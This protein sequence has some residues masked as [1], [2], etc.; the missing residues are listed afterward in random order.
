MGRQGA[1]AHRD[2]ALPL[3]EAPRDGRAQG[4]APPPPDADLG[5]L[6]PASAPIVCPDCK[7]R[8]WL[9]PLQEGGFADL[10]GCRGGA[11]RASAT[12]ATAA[13]ETAAPA[14]VEAPPGGGLLER[15]KRWFG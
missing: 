8:G 6:P 10:C 12:E 11:R 13:P 7:G 9:P 5:A 3:A 15:I 1:L 4:P 14:G 2:R